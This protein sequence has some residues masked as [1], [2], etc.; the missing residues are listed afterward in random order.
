MCASDFTGTPPQNQLPNWLKKSAI[1]WVLL[2]LLTCTPGFTQNTFLDDMAKAEQYLKSSNYIL[3][4][5]IYESYPTQLRLDD[6]YNYARCLLYQRE[7]RKPGDIDEAIRQ[8]KLCSEGGEMRAMMLLAEIY[9]KGEL[10]PQNSSEGIKLLRNLTTYDYPEAL[11][12]YALILQE[13]KLVARNDNQAFAFMST[14]AQKEYRPAIKTVAD[15]YYRG[16]GAPKDTE[17]AIQ[18]WK[19]LVRLDDDSDAAYNIAIVY[20]SRPADQVLGLKELD[21]RAVRNHVPS[22]ALL[23]R[24]YEEGPYG[25]KTDLQK[26]YGYHEYLVKLK[27]AKTN[28]PNEYN[29]SLAV[30][31]KAGS[32][33]PNQDSK[34]LRTNFDQLI[35]FVKSG[36]AKSDLKTID[37]KL[38]QI[39]EAYKALEKI[40]F[41]LV[42][43]KRLR[44]DVSNDKD[45][46]LTPYHVVETKIVHTVEEDKAMEVFLR[47]NRILQKT[48][49]EYSVEGD[50]E[51]ATLI[52]PLPQDEKYA[53]EL[54]KD[55]DQVLLR[56]YYYK[57]LMK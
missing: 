55:E 24:I 52:I 16:I 12:W 31:R 40:G 47:W 13:G 19:Q 15:W 42:S 49:P 17:K 10:V 27:D 25:I 48:Y 2:L 41:R 39:V 20:I 6:R 30:V 37:E 32:V 21:F 43:R 57:K 22:I 8:L 50:T 11:Y 38:K 1:L 51:K 56:F 7:Y 34:L 9:L 5:K 44:G 3:A 53:L 33:E 45:W 35:T 29:R 14:A 54:F 36:H 28:Y 18:Y 4:R 46:L 26:A 23:A